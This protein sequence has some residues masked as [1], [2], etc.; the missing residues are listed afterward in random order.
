MAP[1]CRND[2]RRVGVETL[3]G[4]RSVCLVRSIARARRIAKAAEGR[5]SDS[6]AAKGQAALRLRA[7]QI[8][9][10]IDLLLTELAGGAPVRSAALACL[11]ETPVASQGARARRRAVA[12]P[13]R[14]RRRRAAPRFDPTGQDRKPFPPRPIGDR[15]ADISSARMRRSPGSFRRH[16]RDRACSR[17]RTSHISRP[18]R[19]MKPAGT[20]PLHGLARR[21]FTASC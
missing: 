8:G 5:R 15:S 17:G 11:A 1:V 19:R 20:G 16:G 13:T 9:V 6:G 18:C 3:H 12:E 4:R 10:R 2:R 21:H 14:R 7:T